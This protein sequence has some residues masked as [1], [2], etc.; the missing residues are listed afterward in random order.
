M[1][2]ASSPFGDGE[3]VH[4]IEVQD[5][6]KPDTDYRKLCLGEK[7][8][9]LDPAPTDKSVVSY[10]S[11]SGSSPVAHA[12]FNSCLETQNPTLFHGL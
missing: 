4:Q 2:K 11:E 8:N 9:L 7:N 1:Q 5:F 10:N 12:A 6:M 3:A